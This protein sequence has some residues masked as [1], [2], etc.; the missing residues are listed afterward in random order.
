LRRQQPE[1]IGSSGFLMALAAFAA[2]AGECG[3]AVGS[4][5]QCCATGKPDQ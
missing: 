2:F 5:E 1:A 4:T 3:S